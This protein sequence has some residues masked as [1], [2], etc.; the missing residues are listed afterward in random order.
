MN[1][2][3]SRNTTPT[4]NTITSG[5]SRSPMGYS[6]PASGDR[7]ARS[8]RVSSISRPYARRWPVWIPRLANERAYGYAHNEPSRNRRGKM[9]SQSET[10][11]AEAFEATL[12]RPEGVGTWTYLV[13]PRD[14]EALYGVRGQIKV[15]GTINGQP[16]RSS[17]MPRGDGA[18]YLVVNTSIREQIGATPGDSVMVT[19]E[20]D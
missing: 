4:N 3:T 14:L 8:P 13:I 15:R 7:P 18:H 11:G 19:L 20:R 12:V 2:T 10:P 17:A 1:D 6:P 16:F 5:Q 9:S